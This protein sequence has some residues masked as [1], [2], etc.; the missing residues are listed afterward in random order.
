MSEELD[1]PLIY[2]NGDSYSDQNYHPSLKG[3]TYADV[4]AE[5]CHGFVINSSISGSNNRRIIRSTVYDMLE[6]RKLNKNQKTIAL[7]GLSFE[8]RGELWAEDQVPKNPRE[9]QF[10][11]HEFS[12]L[13]NWR[14]DLL[15]NRDIKPNNSF[16]FNE[17]FYKKYSEGRAYFFSPYAERINLLCDLIMLKT[18][19][20]SLKINFL[21]FQSPRAEKLQSDHLLNFFKNEISNDDRFFDI[22]QFSFLD[23]AF[24]K[25]FSPLDLKNRPEIGH[26][27]PDAH[28]NFATEV[29]IP[30][31]KKQGVL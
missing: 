25:G 15:N 12:G 5:A 16:R 7:I 1:F 2:C 26:Y 4:V 19:F 28:R 20:E 23:W 29:L 8:L 17:K 14:R 18:L 30:T 22:E 10:V 21:I 13:I 31:L 6:H 24:K 11:T 27:G 3:K 9:S